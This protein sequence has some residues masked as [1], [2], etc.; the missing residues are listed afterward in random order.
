MISRFMKKQRQ[1]YVFASNNKFYVFLWNEYVKPKHQKVINSVFL[2]NFIKYL[3]ASIDLQK[4]F[5]R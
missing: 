3:P 1:M 4:Y 5:Q 2:S